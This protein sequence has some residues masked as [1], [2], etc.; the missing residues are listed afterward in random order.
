MVTL[1]F[2]RH[3]PDN[4]SSTDLPITLTGGDVNPHGFAG[5]A[6]QRNGPHTPGGRTGV[7]L[8]RSHL[9]V[10]SDSLPMRVR[11]NF[12]G[13]KETRT[14]S[15]HSLWLLLVSNRNTGRTPGGAVSAIKLL[16]T[17]SRS[18]EGSEALVPVES[19]PA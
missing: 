14:A 11:V 7:V 9:L 16:D 15:V 5:R 3:R 10:S 4:G 18:Y 8:I 12:G 1:D 2:L 19:V 6:C 13:P 17:K